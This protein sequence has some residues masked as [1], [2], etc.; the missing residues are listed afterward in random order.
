[1]KKNSGIET[2]DGK[3]EFAVGGMD[4]PSCASNLEN[5]L[6]QMEGVEEA[7]VDFMNETV[8]V[9]PKR[10][11][12]AAG[13]IAR[14][15]AQAGFQVRNGGGAKTTVLHVD[16]M[17]CSEESTVIEKKLKSLKCVSVVGFNLVAGDMT[18]EHTCAVEEIIGAIASVGYKARALTAA[19]HAPAKTTFWEKRGQAILTAVSGL[20]V[21]IAYIHSYEHKQADAMTYVLY[22]TA[23]ISGGW[24]TARKGIMALRNLS[25]DMN[26][27]MMIAAAGA[28]AI[29]Q[30]SEG[31]M[32]V[33]L[34]AVANLL[35]NYSMERAR[36]A[37][38]AL[39]QVAPNKATAI[40]GGVE[41]DVD[42]GDIRVGEMIV[43]KPGEK[44]PLDGEVVKGGAYVNQ[45]PIT[46]ESRRVYKAAGDEVFAGTLNEQGA[47]EV[48]V[49]KLSADTTL[50]KIIHMIQDAQAQKAPTQR[51]VDKFARYYTPAVIALAALVAAVPPLA[52]GQPFGGWFYRALT[53]LVIACPCALVIST[54][55]AVVSA[56]SAAAKG[57]ALIK[58]GAYLEAMG[59][60][61]AVA[62]DKTGTLT[63][64]VPKVVEIAAARGKSEAEIL[65]VAAAIESRSEHHIA[66]AIVE[67]AKENGVSF[68][69]VDD[70]ESFTGM[71]A[72]GN[73]GGATYYVGNRRLFQEKGLRTDAFDER[74]NAMEGAGRTAALVGDEREALG[75]IALEDA[76]RESGAEAVRLLKKEGIQRVVM[77][78]GDTAAAANE[79]G[80]R[81]K[82]DEVRAGLLPED[83]VAA[84]RE[85]LKKYGAA[86]MVGD[87]V[88]DAPALAAA[89][90][91]VAMGIAGTDAA[92]E[93][94]DIVLMT[95]DLRK[96][97][98][99]IRISRKSVSVIRQNIILALAIK[100]VFLAA[101][102]AGVAT[103]W[104]AVFADMGASL[105]V[106]SNGLRLIGYK[107]VNETKS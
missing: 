81:L 36:R 34:F 52:F 12:A 59:G 8:K 3:I 77:L 62:F 67:K 49:T 40:R 107:D 13:D 11:G 28:A 102:V 5:A 32:V 38:G 95:D 69:G 39:I 79:I 33:F 30:W 64:G 61:R 24:H 86:A 96:L 84:V 88:N 48:R 35:E 26:S 97:S 71:G 44:F 85:L 50:A 41:E 80:A 72:K 74:L 87:G 45:A 103:L 7:R 53:L 46:G 1:V 104:M 47:V 43:I 60:I 15:I 83:K 56:L 2:D 29:G 31:A 16:G 10:G 63:A 105:I 4:C 17:D 6:R 98:F 101:A 82:V 22:L 99:A 89:T 66:K 78:T 73:V 37:V 21:I 100:A 55:V 9:T 54:P 65:S 42:V 51:F 68:P 93:T 58:G 92:L 94:A 20:F 91:G 19:G 25:L 70:F 27:L 18:V 23:M 57:G 75:M 14:K 106:I 90:V 76:G